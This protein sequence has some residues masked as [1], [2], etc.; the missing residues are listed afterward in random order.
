MC[1]H[2]LCQQILIVALTDMKTAERPKVAE[3]QS[4]KDTAVAKIAISEYLWKEPVNQNIQ[5]DC[6]HNTFPFMR[7][8]ASSPNKLLIFIEDYSAV[9]LAY[10]VPMSSGVFSTFV[11]R[12]SLMLGIRLLH[13]RLGFWFGVLG[14]PARPARYSAPST[15]HLR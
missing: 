1:Q 10:S 7:V 15:Q 11:H 4:R 2:T 9:I 14:F 5:L 12:F 6:R 13:S 3:M 8:W